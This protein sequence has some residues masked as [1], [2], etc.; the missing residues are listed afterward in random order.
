MDSLLVSGFFIRL[1]QDFFLILKIQ[2]YLV[3]FHVSPHFDFVAIW[4]GAP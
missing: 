2:L 3:G 1:D 4:H